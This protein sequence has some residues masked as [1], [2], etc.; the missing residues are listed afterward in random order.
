MQIIQSRRDFLASLS[1]T[2]AASVLGCGRSLA[3]EGPPETTTIRIRREPATETVRLLDQAVEKP[4]CIAPEYMAEELLSAEGFTDIQY[5]A[6][7]ENFT[8]PELVARGE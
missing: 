5:V 2:T 6:A 1:A 3:D 7:P 4:L 8:F